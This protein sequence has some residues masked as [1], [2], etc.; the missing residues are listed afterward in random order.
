MCGEIVFDVLSDR[1]PQ[2]LEWLDYGFYIG[3]PAGAFPPGVTATCTVQQ[4]ELNCN[5]ADMMS[6]MLDRWLKFKPDAAWED[7]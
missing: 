3:I 7:V 4:V 5:A 1:L 6:D 2:K